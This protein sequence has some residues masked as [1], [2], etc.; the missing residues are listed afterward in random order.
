MAKRREGRAGE[1]YVALGAALQELREANGLNQDGLALQVGLSR[2]SIANIEGGRQAVPLHH[3]AEM[4]AALG[5]TASAIIHVIESKPKATEQ[6]PED[7]PTAV[8]A[9]VRNRMR[10][11]P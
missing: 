2:A 5:T 3:L 1:L 6:M 9:F 4:A 10:L 11:A 7:L 8:M